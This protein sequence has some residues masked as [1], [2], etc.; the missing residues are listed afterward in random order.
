MCTGWAK[1]DEKNSTNL[2]EN[3]RSAL[4]DCLLLLKELHVLL[5][6]V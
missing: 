3:L 2:V 4:I 1:D 6:I 5:N